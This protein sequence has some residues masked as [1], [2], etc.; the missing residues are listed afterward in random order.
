M[1][2]L[3]DTA[4]RYQILA[5]HTSDVIVDCRLDGTITW[6]SPSVTPVL[7]WLAAEVVGNSNAER[8]VPD[9]RSWPGDDV[10]RPRPE[11][12]PSNKI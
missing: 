1:F 2:E 6:V 11:K 9:P 10:D 8:R 12:Q 5:S 4:R 3:E 7:G